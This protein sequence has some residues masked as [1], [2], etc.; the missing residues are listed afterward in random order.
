MEREPAAKILGCA[1]EGMQRVSVGFGK[2]AVYAEFRHKCFDAN[3]QGFELVRIPR[4]PVM[5][6]R[7]DAGRSHCYL[8]VVSVVKSRLF[9]RMDSPLGLIL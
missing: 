8:L 2:E 7:S 9:L 3:G 4:K 6:E 1:M 5:T